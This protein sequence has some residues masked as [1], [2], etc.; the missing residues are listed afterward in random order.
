MPFAE[1]LTVFFSDFGVTATPTVGAA[2]TVIFD[3]AFLSSLGVES[4]GPV[5]VARTADVAALAHGSDLTVTGTPGGTDDGVYEI[6][7]IQPDGTGISVL[8]LRSA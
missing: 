3:R 7:G 4:T 2:I 8:Q 1:D 5:C 6:T